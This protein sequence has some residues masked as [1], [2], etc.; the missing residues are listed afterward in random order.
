ML[1]LAMPPIHVSSS[2]YGRGYAQF[3]DGEPPT[4]RVQ[5]LLSLPAD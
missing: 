2:V 4:G 3:E 1:K 5:N